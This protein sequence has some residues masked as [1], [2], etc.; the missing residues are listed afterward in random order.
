MAGCWAIAEAI[1]SGPAT[2]AMASGLPGKAG[3]SNGRVADSMIQR[4]AGGAQ[5]AASNIAMSTMR[6]GNGRTRA[7]S[8]SGLPIRVISAIDPSSRPRGTR[9]LRRIGLR[10]SGKTDLGAPHRKQTGGARMPGGCEVF[11]ATVRHPEQIGG[12]RL[13]PPGGTVSLTP[14][15]QEWC[16]RQ[17]SLA[18]PAQR[19]GPSMAVETIRTSRWI[20]RGTA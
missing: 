11:L 16:Q 6:P 10:T 12:Q 2:A 19:G 17:T 4:R 15:L 1:T 3:A 8:Q 20:T 18:P 5:C 13:T 14:R 9:R 7:G